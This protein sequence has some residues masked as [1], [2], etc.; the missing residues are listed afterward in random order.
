MS[1]QMSIQVFGI[2]NCQSVKKARDWLKDKGVEYEFHDF[3]KAGI[4]E[5]HLKKWITELGLDVILNKKGMTWRQLSKEDQDA[6]V[7]EK[8]A[9]QAMILHTSL[10][11]RPIIEFGKRGICVGVN[12]EAW[13][14]VI[15]L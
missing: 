3:K 5:L 14:S 12:P 8:T 9:I 7:D 11:K 4:D 6:I 2:T 1:K 15:G 10:I 13:S